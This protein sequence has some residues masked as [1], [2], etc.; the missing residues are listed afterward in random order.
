MCTIC[1]V[2]CDRSA[3]C[4]QRAND[5]MAEIRRS[6]GRLLRKGAAFVQQFGAVARF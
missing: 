4:I 2:V 5:Q 3:F 1:A 6:H